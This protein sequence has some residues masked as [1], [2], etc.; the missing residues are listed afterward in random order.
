MIIGLTSTDQSLSVQS[1]AKINDGSYDRRAS[2][3]FETKDFSVLRDL[4][5]KGHS[6]AQFY[7]GLAYDKGDGVREDDVVAADWYQ[8]D[9]TP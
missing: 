4:A 5:N 6:S 1:A 3:A 2:Y 8:S 9:L 7:L